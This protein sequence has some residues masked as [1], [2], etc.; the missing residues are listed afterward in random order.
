MLQITTHTPT[1]FPVWLAKHCATALCN[2]GSEMSQV[3]HDIHHDEPDGDTDMRISVASMPMPN[4]E[5]V[6]IGWAAIHT[7]G[8]VSSIQAFVFPAYRR[9]GL[10]SALVSALTALGDIPLKEAA[11]FTPHMLNAAYRSG[12]HTAHVWKRSDEGWQRVAD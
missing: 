5:E 1:N 2:Q 6:A 10:C 8:N 12:F 9:R 4:G 7:W 11:V 3:F